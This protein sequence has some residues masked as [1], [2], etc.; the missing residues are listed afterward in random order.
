MYWPVIKSYLRD[1]Y[2]DTNGTVMV[3]T[4]MTLPMLFWGLA[5]M[6]EFFEIHR[7]KSTR[8]KA[9]YTIADLIS[10]EN[11]VITDTYM[12]NAKILFD[13]I[14]DDYGENQLRISVI[15]YL[16]TDDEYEI[17]WSE[18][19]GNGSMIALVNND[20]VDGHDFLPIMSDGEELI[21][22]QTESNYRTIF[23]IGFSDDVRVETSV[24][25]S[26]RF[27][28]QICYDSCS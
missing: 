6:F 2:E 3:E 9:T 13:E 16:E 19:R 1:F 7:Y 27:A 5:A 12:D 28:P 22:V 8:D 20:V 4:V 25:T 14:A 17:S 18:V 11:D 21:L 24:F 26:I 23:D 10:R 15:R